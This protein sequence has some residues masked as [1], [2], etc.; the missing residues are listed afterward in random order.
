[1]RLCGIFSRGTAPAAG[2][3]ALV[4][5]RH[6]H[7]KRLQGCHGLPLF[8]ACFVLPD[9]EEIWSMPL[10]RF[11]ARAGTILKL[12]AGGLIVEFEHIVIALHLVVSPQLHVAALKSDGAAHFA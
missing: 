7:C 5:L 10:G 4:P 11:A 1:M 12:N 9:D 3:F 8:K 6:R 2:W